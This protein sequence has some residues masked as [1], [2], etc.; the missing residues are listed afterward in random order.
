MFTKEQQIQLAAALSKFKLDYYTAETTNTRDGFIKA[1][2]PAETIAKLLDMEC[3]PNANRNQAAAPTPS[4]E[5]ATEQ[6]SSIED[7]EKM[8]LDFKNVLSILDDRNDVVIKAGSQW[9]KY[10]YAAYEKLKDAPTL[11]RENEK[12][13]RLLHDLTPGGSEFYN[14]PEYCAK[15]IRESRTDAHY[16]MANIIKETKDENKKLREVLAELMS[17]KSVM[18]TGA[19]TLQF[20]DNFLKA[21]DQAKELLNSK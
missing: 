1:K 2:M 11:Y 14:D 12:L 16:S 13:K 7:D 6:S 21:I 15:W 19:D 17:F 10:L 8:L 9:H 5:E 3:W 4:V 20:P 18:E